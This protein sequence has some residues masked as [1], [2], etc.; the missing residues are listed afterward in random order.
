M[1]IL[2]SFEDFLNE[3]RN[4]SFSEIVDSNGKSLAHLPY[5]NKPNIQDSYRFGFTFKSVK[6][7]DDFLT[8][9]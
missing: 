1:E 3:G 6:D 2:K 7:I 4:Y 9:P 5:F 8:Q